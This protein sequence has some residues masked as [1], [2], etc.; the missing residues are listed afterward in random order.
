MKTISTNFRTELFSQQSAVL[1]IVLLQLSHTDFSGTLYIT[2]TLLTRFTDSPYTGGVTSNGIN[3]TYWPMNIIWPDDVDSRPPQARVEVMGVPQS[4]IQEVRKVITPGTARM[5]LCTSL[6]VNTYEEDL[7]NLDF[8]AFQ[9]S[10][11]SLILN[12]SRNNLGQEPYP[13]PMITPGSF[14]SLFGA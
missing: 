13:G 9:N 11:S 10:S 2:D 14:P 6:D 8:V 1:A 12:F 5:M 4:I 3:Y 7:Q